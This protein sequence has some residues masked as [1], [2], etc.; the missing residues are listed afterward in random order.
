MHDLTEISEIDVLH[1]NNQIEIITDAME[2]QSIV[3]EYVKDGPFSKEFLFCKLNKNARRVIKWSIRRERQRA[4][5]FAFLA[6]F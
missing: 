4:C 1:K 6:L 5:A 3:S 2:R